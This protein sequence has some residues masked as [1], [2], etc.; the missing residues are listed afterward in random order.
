MPRHDDQADAVADAVFVDLL[1]EH[2]SRKT[3]PAVMPDYADEPKA[4]RGSSSRRNAGVIAKDE[5]AALD[6]A[7]PEGPLDQANE[8]RR[9]ARV[10]S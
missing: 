10:Y 5:L 1:A 3:V 2:T 8:D 4:K 9:V 7:K 6:V